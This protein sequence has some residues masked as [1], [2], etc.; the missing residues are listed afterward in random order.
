[1]E[2]DPYYSDIRLHLNY[3]LKIKNDSVIGL[4]DVELKLKLQVPFQMSIGSYWRGRNSVL[5]GET[6]VSHTTALGNIMRSG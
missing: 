6:H 2:R 3:T 4:F 5:I 1:M